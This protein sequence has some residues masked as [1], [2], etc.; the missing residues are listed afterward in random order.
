MLGLLIYYVTEGCDLGGAGSGARET[1][2]GKG[3]DA[4]EWRCSGG[5]EFPDRDVT[6]VAG[7]Q[8]TL[9]NFHFS[10]RKVPL[11]TSGCPFPSMLCLVA[12]VCGSP[13][14]PSHHS[15]QPRLPNAVVVL[16]I[17]PDPSSRPSRMGILFPLLLGRFPSNLL[18]IIL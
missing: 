15:H 10:S 14:V 8:D 3:E 11:S 16:I 2:E 12:A 5:A 1:N 7:H 18:L 4:G 6:Q 13:H 9:I 17:P